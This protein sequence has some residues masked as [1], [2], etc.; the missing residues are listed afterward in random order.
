MTT[1]LGLRL[2]ALTL[3][4]AGLTI[5]PVAAGTAVAADSHTHGTVAS[6]AHHGDSHGIA[7]A[8]AGRLPLFDSPSSDS[9][10]TWMLGRPGLHINVDCAVWEHGLRGNVMWYRTDPDRD[11]DWDYIPS[12]DLNLNLLGL[13]LLHLRLCGGL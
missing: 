2:A 13:H 6:S 11:G 1:R 3:G 8:V 5:A 12:S 9:R 4:V 10:L 7:I